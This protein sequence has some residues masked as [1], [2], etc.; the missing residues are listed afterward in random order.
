MIRFLQRLFGL[1]SDSSSSTQT[2]IERRRTPRTSAS[3]VLAETH[4]APP[5]EDAAE[6]PAE[7]VEPELSLEDP[8]ISLKER[9]EDVRKPYDTGRFNQPDAWGRAKKRDDN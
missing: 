9:E 6:E 7:P 5:A 4:P 1:D 3:S 8:D 2:G